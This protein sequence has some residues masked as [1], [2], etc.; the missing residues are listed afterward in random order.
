MY[1]I[2]L[3]LGRIFEFKFE[4]YLFLF[5]TLP[6]FDKVK[7]DTSLLACSVFSVIA[8]DVKLFIPL[9]LTLQYYIPPQNFCRQ[10]REPKFL[11]MLQ[12]I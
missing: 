11:S 8:S 6:P 2:I 5:E 3:C 12:G 9:R 10:R 7:V 4:I 1:N